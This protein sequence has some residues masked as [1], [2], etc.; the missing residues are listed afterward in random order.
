MNS[1]RLS[2]NNCLVLL[3]TKA[4]ST[5]LVLDFVETA[6]FDFLVANSDRHHVERAIGSFIV[7]NGSIL[8][9]DNGKSL[10]V[11][12]IYMYLFIQFVN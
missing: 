1:S 7:K 4:L 8:L 2:E 9:I 5:D 12:P 6:V 11:V 3:I 10:V